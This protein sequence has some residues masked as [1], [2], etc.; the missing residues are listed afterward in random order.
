VSDDQ[1]FILEQ[2][3][4][5]LH[6]QNR[7]ASLVQLKEM[8]GLPEYRI[9]KERQWLRDAGFM[10]LHFKP[11]RNVDGSPVGKPKPKAHLPTAA[12]LKAAYLPARKDTRF[13]FAVWDGFWIQ[14]IKGSLKV[15]RK[16][17]MPV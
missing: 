4:E 17:R 12:E 5:W 9:G 6:E 10:D 1:E 2:A 8:T 16:G 13:D 11:L 15:W 14:Y 3:I 7:I